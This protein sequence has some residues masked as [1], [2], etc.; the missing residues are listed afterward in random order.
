[1]RGAR[2]GPVAYVLE[3]YPRLS[4][5]FILNELLELER[6]GL[7]LRIFSLK[8]PDDGVFHGDT[9]RLQAPVTYLPP[10]RWRNAPRYVGPHARC[11]ARRPL[12]YLGRFRKVLA[13]GSKPRVKRFLQAGYIAPSLR[14]AGVEHVHAHFASTPTSVTVQLHELTG[15]PFSFTAHAK[16]IFHESVDPKYV[17]RKLELARFTVTVSDYNR[18]YL[19][20][21]CERADLV[22]IYNG[23]DLERF[24][25]DSAERAEPPLVL[26]VGR[27]IEKKGFADLV[28]ACALLRRG[29][30]RLRCLIIG[31]GPLR[32][33]LQELIASLRLD[34]AVELAGALPR[35]QLLQLYRQASV[36]AAPSVICPDGNRDGLPT[37]LVEAMALGIPV[38]ATRVAGIPE[39]VAHEHTGLLVRQQDPEELAGAIERLITDP[40][41]SADLAR[42]GRGLVEREFDLRIN[43]AELRN[44]F[45]LVRSAT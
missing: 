2:P 32:S 31:K 15:V 42:A 33:Q 43:V 45:E 36:L 41:L 39:L 27:L 24:A 35:E 30:L 8:E 11:L 25:A 5:T 9:A 21:L 22:R 13:S 4:E 28:Q 34:D 26:G 29:G 1:M 44:R 40:A 17:K 18:D 10:L 19:G 20:A 37:V 23:L 7:T 3:M 12:R 6:Q 14:R 38:V 16:D